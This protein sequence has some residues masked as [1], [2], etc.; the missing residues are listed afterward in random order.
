MKSSRDCRA[1]PWYTFF[2]TSSA[3]KFAS[4]PAS[5]STPHIYISTLALWLPDAPV[6]VHHRKRMRG[7]VEIHNSALAS[8]GPPLQ[9]R[10]SVSN[11]VTCLAISPDGIHLAISHGRVISIWEAYTG[12]K[13]LGPLEGHAADVSSVAYSPDGSRIVSGSFDATIYVWDAHTG[14]IA[15]R[16]S[17]SHT[18]RIMS[19]TYLPDSTRIISC[20][21]EETIRVWD[22]STSEI[23]HILSC[24]VSCLFTRPCNHGFWR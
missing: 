11:V 14:R 7:L 15:P 4:S 9:A 12:Q 20:S 16:L 5:L 22:A 24:L 23:I 21:F 19:V 10:W 17:K 1:R 18:S 13:T 6:S 8:G 2:G 3:A